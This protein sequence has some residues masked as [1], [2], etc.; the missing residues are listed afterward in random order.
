MLKIQP[1]LALCTFLLTLI[2][3]L[4]A[5]AD[6]ITPSDRVTSRLRVRAEANTDSAIIGFL[7][8]QEERRLLGDVP[9]W[10]KIEWEGSFGFV[11][12][13]WSTAIPESTSA[14]QIRLGMWNIQK[15]GWN[16]GK[17]FSLLADLI[18]DNFDILAVVEVMQ[19]AGG[20]RGYTDLMD[21]LGNEWKGFIT[22]RPR[23]NTA[24]SHSE[25][26][27]VIFRDQVAE[28][29]SDE[30][31]YF[32][33]N[34]T[35]SPLDG[36]DLF[37]REPAY[38]CLETCN[39]N[40]DFILGA[41]HAIFASGSISKIK[42]EVININLVFS[43]WE[44]EFPNEHDLLLMGDYNLVP[45]RL[46]EVV[47]ANDFTVGSASTL[48]LGELTS[49]LYDHILIQDL[50]ATSEIPEEAIVLDLRSFASSNEDFFDTISDHLPIVANVECPDDDDD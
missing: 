47:T 40:F 30:L 11:S 28:A 18:E 22:E 31:E 16:N 49:N 1:K 2:T 20:H 38:M 6:T 12:K 37:R 39:G 3:A 43:F 50:D 10:Y 45:S 27:A 14:N 15:L 9:R 35:S 17:D 29:C 13:S 44:T 42:Q 36:E 5:Y 19:K 25:F 4:Q 41:Y 24:S 33:D 8:P 23:P 32:E 26:Y 48:H 7:L 21:A 34:T 46:L